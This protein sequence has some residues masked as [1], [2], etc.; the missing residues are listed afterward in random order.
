[1]LP[2]RA[3]G[4]TSAPISR[5]LPSMAKPVRNIGAS[6]RT[7]LLVLAK[8]QNQL[9]D[10]VLKRFVLERLLY[11]LSLSECRSRFILKGG[12][13]VAT[14]LASA[15]RTTRD[16]DFLGFGDPDPEAI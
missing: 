7:R 16:I 8:S 12:M 5:R 3:N 10:V 11:R 15:Y 13:L 14:W 1:M 9:F 2:M 6:V 4:R